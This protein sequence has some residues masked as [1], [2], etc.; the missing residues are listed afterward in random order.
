MCANARHPVVPALPLLAA[1][2]LDVS[3]SQNRPE[4]DNP[5]DAAVSAIVRRKARSLVG[6]AGLTRQDVADVE[7]ELILRLLD[8]LGTLGTAAPSGAGRL[9]YV[10]RLVDRFAL[11]L[12]RARRA[13]KRDPGPITS[14]AAPL[15]GSDAKDLGD[16]VGAH[17]RAAVRG[18]APRD[19]AELRLLA[20][21]V[22]AVLDRLP[23]DLRAIAL[24]LMQ[25]SL[26]ALARRRG[27][28]RSTLRDR[29]RGIRDR[30]ARENLHES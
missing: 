9:A 16:T 2:E 5:I 15:A 10:Q 17:Q 12:L 8:V 27:V 22:A 18:A 7:Q 13:A 11:N 29:L 23:D 20:L 30:L 1:E 3:D 6:S 21:D 4:R 28:P 25:E 26:T 24:G 19:D 14:L